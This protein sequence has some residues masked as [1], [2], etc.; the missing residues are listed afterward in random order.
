[1]LRPASDDQP[2]PPDAGARWAEAERLLSGTPD[3]AA[4][5]RLRRTRRRQ[6][7]AVLG[8]CLGASVLA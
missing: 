2:V 3:A 4:E 6:V 8:A 5:R 1:M 7:L